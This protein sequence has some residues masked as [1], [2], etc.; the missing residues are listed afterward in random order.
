MVRITIISIIEGI[1][2]PYANKVIKDA[3]NTYIAEPTRDTKDNLL[4]A[5]D[6]YLSK[7]N[8]Q[9]LSYMF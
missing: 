3:Y 7:M 8:E 2:D 4:E 1:N 9:H 6:V 5:L